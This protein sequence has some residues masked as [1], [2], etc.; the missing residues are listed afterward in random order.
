MEDK[1]QLGHTGKTIIINTNG[2]IFI[3]DS[4]DEEKLNERMEELSTYYK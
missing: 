3:F 1:K 4:S 2:M